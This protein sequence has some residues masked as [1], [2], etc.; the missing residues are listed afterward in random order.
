MIQLTGIEGHKTGKQYVFFSARKLEGFTVDEFEWMGVA[1]NLGYRS[2]FVRDTGNEFY[3][4]KNTRNIII[5]LRGIV[6]SFPDETIFVGSSM[7]AYGAI[8]MAFTAHPARVIAFSPSPPMNDLD[9]SP[10]FI[11]KHPSKITIHVGAHS[12]HAYTNEFNDV[13]NALRYSSYAEIIKHDTDVHNVAKFL[14]KKGKLE[15]VLL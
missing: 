11:S 1:K 5:L 6:K 14:K 15:G 2:Y 9:Y 3:N 12:K 13:E 10:E 4:N 8:N 7:G